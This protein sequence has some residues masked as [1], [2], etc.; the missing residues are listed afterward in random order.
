MNIKKWLKAQGT[1]IRQFV[2]CLAGAI[3]YKA[4]DIT[5]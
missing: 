2:F 5:G 3:C 4:L 1:E